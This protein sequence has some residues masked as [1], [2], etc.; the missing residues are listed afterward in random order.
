M[1]TL[2]DLA[3]ISELKIGATAGGGLDHREV[4]QD[5]Y[6]L[7]LLLE[8]AER[9]SIELPLAYVGILDNNARRKYRREGLEKRL[10]SVA[11]HPGVQLLWFSTTPDR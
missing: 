3:V 9:R 6:K 4:A 11:H 5:V 8:E 2:A 10:R 1:A 7:S